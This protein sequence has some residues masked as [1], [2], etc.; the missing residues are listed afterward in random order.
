MKNKTLLTLLA[1]LFLLN[2]T[3]F[4]QVQKTVKQKT[5]ASK[6]SK[7]RVP[8]NSF[9]GLIPVESIRDIDQSS[10]AFHAISELYN[11]Q[12][13]VAYADST[14]RPAQLLKRG[15]FMVYF[16]EALESS[17]RLMDSLKM[18]TTLVN[19]Y[20]KNASYITSVSEIK[21]LNKSSIYFP[22]VQSMIERWGI[23]AMFTKAKLL[24]AN[25]AIS[26]AEV[27]DILKVTLGYEK[28]APSKK[29][30][31][32][33]RDAFV[34]MLADAISQM[35]QKAIRLPKP[36]PDKISDTLYIQLPFDPTKK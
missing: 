24:N 3:S 6:T 14:F 23:A 17:R 30:G 2:N 31:T 11:Y 25:A 19:T 28:L 7:A 21:D 26:E 35:R 16:N 36:I 1:A 27:Y 29:S 9:A 20:D 4:S 22:A 18:D 5:V 34:V 13:P 10:A 32:I 15:D 12:V 33:R 8:V